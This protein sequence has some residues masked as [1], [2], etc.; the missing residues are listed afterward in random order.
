[1]AEKVKSQRKIQQNR[2]CP[3]LPRRERNGKLLEG[4][5]RERAKAVLLGEFYKDRLQREQA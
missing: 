1:V 4:Q 5:C 2:I 3:I